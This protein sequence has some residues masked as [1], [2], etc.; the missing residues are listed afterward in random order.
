MTFKLDYTL[1]DDP[2][3]LQYEVY[4]DDMRNR[5]VVDRVFQEDGSF[6]W[7]VRDEMRQCLSTDGEWAYES[8]PS[9]R[10][11]DWIATHRFDDFEVAWGKAKIAAQGILAQAEKRVA[12]MNTKDAERDADS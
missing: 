6:K 4:R 8:M 12:F 7:A 1:H 11:E 3:A 9:N 5:V 10:P 2:Y